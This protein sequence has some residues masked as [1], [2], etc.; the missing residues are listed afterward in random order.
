MALKKCKECGEKVSSKAKACPHCGAPLRKE[1][2]KSEPT[3]YSLGSLIVL[4]LFGWFMY[5]IW[6]GDSNL[7]NPAPA[8]DWKS[9]N[10]RM[11]AYTMMEDFVKQSLTAPT[12]AKFPAVSEG[13]GDHIKQL[14]NQTYEI[15]SWVESQNPVGGTLRMRFNGQ[16]QQ[17]A[18]H[19]WQLISLK[20]VE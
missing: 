10:N 13:K 8:A 11:M 17:T 12:M 15:D 6:T 14:E 16:I 2:A 3:Q 20:F 4:C 7:D 5:T 1:K 18:E 9:Q 19:E